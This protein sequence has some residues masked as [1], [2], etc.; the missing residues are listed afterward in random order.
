M[1]CIS[2]LYILFITIVH[3]VSSI[4]AQPDRRS[5]LLHGRIQGDKIKDTGDDECITFRLPQPVKIGDDLVTTFYV[6]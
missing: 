1:I 6:S 3:Q 4:P 2:I 5:L